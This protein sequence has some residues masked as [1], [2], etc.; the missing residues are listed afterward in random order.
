[1]EKDISK[2]GLLFR[3]FGRREE[4]KDCCK[5]EFQTIEPLRENQNNDNY[6]K[7]NN[8]ERSSI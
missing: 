7:D 4:K 2:K 6:L 8:K 3:L 5:I 1:M